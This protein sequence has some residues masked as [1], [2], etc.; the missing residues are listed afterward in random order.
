MNHSN[1]DEYFPK[2]GVGV[3][4]RGGHAAGAWR[5]GGLVRPQRRKGGGSDRDSARSVART[6]VRARVGEGVRYDG[7]A[8]G[9]LLWADPKE[10]WHL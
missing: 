8:V 2:H 4:F 10:Q 7:P 6:G 3:W 9:S 1:K 5:G